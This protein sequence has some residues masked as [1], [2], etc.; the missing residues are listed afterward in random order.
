MSNV[1]L[2]LEQKGRTWSLDAAA[3]RAARH[4]FGAITWTF[5]VPMDVQRGE[6]TLVPENG[7]PATVRVR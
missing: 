2:F 6:A 5:E 4:D 3:A 1:E 7:Q